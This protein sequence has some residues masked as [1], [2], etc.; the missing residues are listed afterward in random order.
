M[1][2]EGALNSRAQCTAWDLTNRILDDMGDRFVLPRQSLEYLAQLHKYYRSEKV[3]REI[4]NDSSPEDNGEGL[5]EYK[6]QGFEIA[7]V[8]SDTH[9]DLNWVQKRTPGDREL[10]P[11][12]PHESKDQCFSLRTEIHASSG[13]T[14]V[15]QAS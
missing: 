10:S 11:N 3:R 8:E 14:A 9:F 2:P 7:D 13:F 4:S 6:C 15:N 12:E 1:D 5:K